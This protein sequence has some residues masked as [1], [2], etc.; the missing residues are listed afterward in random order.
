MY[1][2]YVDYIC[3]LQ[4]D[5]GT[6]SKLSVNSRE[7]FQGQSQFF[8]LCLYGVEHMGS[9]EQICSTNPKKGMLQPWQ[10]VRRF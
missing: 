1:V 8:Q 4:V 5:H 7:S 3:T 6:I 10:V 2:Y 9:S